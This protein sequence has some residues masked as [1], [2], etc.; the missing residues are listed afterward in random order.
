MKLLILAIDGLEAN[1]VEKWNLKYLKQQ[2]HGTYPVESLKFS[3]AFLWSSFL[4]G[5]PPE[6][7][8]AKF[9]DS[10]TPQLLKKI[11]LP[12]LIKKIG[13]KIYKPTLK[14]FTIK[15]QHKTLFEQVKPSLP[16][17]VFIYNEEKEQFNLRLKYPILKILL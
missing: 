2:F 6:N 1:K 16:Y 3:S 9:V 5:V 10:N 13:K 4:T 7:L 17:N 11:P 14:P 15:Q 12:N 8:N